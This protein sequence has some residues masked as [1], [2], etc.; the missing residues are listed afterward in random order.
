MTNSEYVPRVIR[1][2]RDHIEFD[3]VCVLMFYFPSSR[4]KPT[5]EYVEQTA[6][7]NQLN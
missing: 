1:Q 4:H 7:H 3:N 5:Y 6:P 2:A